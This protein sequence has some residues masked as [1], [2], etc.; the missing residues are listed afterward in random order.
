MAYSIAYGSETRFEREEVIEELKSILGS[1]VSVLETDRLL[2]GKDWWPITGSWMVKGKMPSLPDAVVWPESTEEISQI[3][4]IA[5]SCRVPVIPYGEGSGV[6]GGVVAVQG[7]IVIDMKRM[8]HLLGID[9]IS[10]L[11]TVET[12]INGEV[13]EREL[14]T[15]GYTLRH[16]P[17]SVR[18]ST[19]GGWVSCRAAGQFST[20]YGKIEDMLLG[21]EAVLP[22]GSVYKNTIAPRTA[23]GPRLDQ[24]FLGA[25]GT[26]GVVTKAVL[27]IWPIPEAQRFNSFAFPSLESGLAAIRDILQ[28]NIKPAV[29]RLYDAPETGHHFPDMPE[30]SGKL[31]LV[32][33]MEGI[34]EMVE[35]EN[36]VCE[37]VCQKWGAESCGKAPVEHWF[38]SRF[39]VSLSSPLIQNGAIVDT[40]EVSSTWTNIAAVYEA[41]TTA[42]KEIP[43]TVLVGGHFS[44][45]YTD[46][47]CLY[48]TVVGV[49][50]KDAEEYYRLIW[51]KAMLATREAGG[52]ISH[53]HGVGLNRGRFMENEHGQAGM[54][55]LQEI[56]R[57]LDPDNIMNPGKLGLGR[58]A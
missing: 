19:V 5:S 4:K 38:K 12:G 47:A 25:E 9:E 41:T 37:R 50:Q 36:R 53:H 22:D 17:Q 58:E 44:H 56:K 20:K 45:A 23:T 16:V 3:L 39:N 48:L 11:A 15:R 33:V 52:S 34:Q 6:L 57:A 28:Q 55:V 18:C 42:L 10:H 2:A 14:N 51:D 31:M 35:V 40:I 13:L 1:R 21:L 27:R 8:N 32:L 30:L 43:G 26:F 49:P 46:G 7:G 54:K 29:V 24:L